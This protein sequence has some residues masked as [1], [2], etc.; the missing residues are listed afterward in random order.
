MDPTPL[1]QAQEIAAG[2]AL[3]TFLRLISTDDGRRELATHPEQAIGDPPWSDL[4]EALKDFLHRLNPPELNGLNSVVNSFT[5]NLVVK[6]EPSEHPPHAGF[7]T[8][9]KF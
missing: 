1:T 9:C 8:L 6:E 5:P 2:E 7:A 3:R 4:P